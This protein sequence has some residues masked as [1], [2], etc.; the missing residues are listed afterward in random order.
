MLRPAIRAGLRTRRIPTTAIRSFSVTSRRNM[1]SEALPAVASPINS[2]LPSDSFQ[3]LSQESKAGAAED[4]LYDAQVKEVKK[5]WASPR[6]KDIKRPY[7]AE[8]VVKRRG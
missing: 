1:P 7:S 4:A 5:W 2:I 3:L 8:D 6:Y